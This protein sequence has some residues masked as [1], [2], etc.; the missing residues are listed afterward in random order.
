MNMVI[1]KWWD[2]ECTLKEREARKAL[3]AG[4]KEKKGRTS[5]RKREKSTR[6]NVWRQERNIKRNRKKW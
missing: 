1:N 2:K 4:E 5:I 6:R 3:R